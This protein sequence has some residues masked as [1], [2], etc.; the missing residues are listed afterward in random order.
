MN[1]VI[2]EIKAEETSAKVSQIFSDKRTITKNVNVED[3][4]ELIRLAS[5]DNGR[6]RDTG[7]MSPNLIRESIHNGQ[8]KRLYIY[9]ELKFTCKLQFEYF[10]NIHESVSF[11]KDNKYGIYL[12]ND[13]HGNELVVFP[14]F[15]LRNFG[16]LI[17][18]GNTEQFNC[19]SHNY[20]CISTD[21]FDNVTDNSSLFFT[22]L[23]HFDRDVCWH[24]SFD[25]NSLSSRD[26]IIQGK[27]VYNYVNSIFNNDL[28]L[29]N[30]PSQDAISSFRNDG[31]ED[32]LVDLFGSTF[33]RIISNRSDMSAYIVNIA[34]L[35]YLTTHKNCK[36]EEIC[37]PSGSSE[38][39]EIK[40]GEY[41]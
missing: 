17:V 32:F 35:Y 25:R 39:G 24:G 29:R 1:S 12:D 19:V 31:L 38:D 41:F 30:T 5:T 34:I 2:I 11:N 9:P 37:V 20:G 36:F 26:T 3:L 23:N 18:N 22:L 6:D 21:F 4:P 16:L 13:N 40:L 27:T 33:D 8:V 28:Y 10:Y 15:K 14:D 7:F